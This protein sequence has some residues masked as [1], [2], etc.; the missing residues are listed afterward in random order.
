M[1]NV[2]KNKF[3]IIFSVFILVI[4]TFCSISKCAFTDDADFYWPDDVKPYPLDYDSGDPVSNQVLV[5]CGDT[6]YCLSYVTIDYI[7]GTQKLYLDSNNRINGTSLDH[8]TA[9][10]YNSDS[11]SWSWC[12]WGNTNTVNSTSSGMSNLHQILDS[13]EVISTSSNI[14][15]DDT[16]TE[17]F[18]YVPPQQEI[19]RILVAETG[20]VQ[21]MEQLRKMIVG[22]LKYLAVFLVSLI[23]FWKGW[24]F[25]STQLKKA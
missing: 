20:K 8:I 16:F 6:Y 1:K 18:F 12:S 4:N 2:L 5:K 23:A 21:I 11:E 15:T 9:H 25:L 3:F 24:Q 7:Y 13:C 22:F 17:I 10:K 14:Y 19:T